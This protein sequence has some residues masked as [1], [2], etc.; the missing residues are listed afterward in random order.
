MSNSNDILSGFSAKTLLGDDAHV[1]KEIAALLH[2][3][4]YS[5]QGSEIS[6]DDAF[7][8]LQQ[9]VDSLPS[10]VLDMDV[11]PGTE[12]E[13]LIRLSTSQ[14][15]V[16]DDCDRVLRRILEYQ[17]KLK[18]A[19]RAIKKY[20]ADFMAW[21]ILA[22][23]YVVMQ[24][25]IKFPPSQVKQLAEAEFTR[26]IDNVDVQVD[27]LISSVEHLTEEARQHKKIQSE[28]HS[29]GKDQ[30]NASWTSNLG[31]PNGIAPNRADDMA[32]E[33]A[34]E[35]EEDEVPAFVSRSPK[36]GSLVDT[37]HGLAE[38]GEPGFLPSKVVTSNQDLLDEAKPGDT[39]VLRFQENVAPTLEAIK[40]TVKIT[41]PVTLPLA[42]PEEV[43]DFLNE[44]DAPKQAAVMAAG[45]S[46]L[47][48]RKRL[49][50]TEDEELM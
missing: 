41:G 7:I 23:S 12:N 19:E 38:V 39:V 4:R 3:L 9:A 33:F 29:L 14:E 22:A 26:L 21:Y 15:K 28:K 46:T 43:A 20:R 47:K 16:L 6:L 24:H 27:N 44:D 18:N 31:N 2:D 37:S 1:L 49:I 25:K 45:A 42:T 8:Q 34:E 11:P 40:D 50:L 36:V 13:Y 32:Q 35:D 5:S 10:I 30:A 17:S 48:S